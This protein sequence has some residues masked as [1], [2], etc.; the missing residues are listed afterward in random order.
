MN[1]EFLRSQLSENYLLVEAKPHTF[2]QLVDVI[3]SLD[4]DFSEDIED[5]VSSIT[6]DADILEDESQRLRQSFNSLL[7]GV[8]QASRKRYPFDEL[9]VENDPLE[10]FS[11]T[12]G[13]NFVRVVL[14][15]ITDLQAAHQYLLKTAKNMHAEHI[16]LFSRK[17]VAASFED[18]Q[19]F[20]VQFQM[21]SPTVSSFA[22]SILEAEDCLRIMVATGY[23]ISN[24]LEG[25]YKTLNHRHSSEGIEIHIDPITT[26]IAMAIYENVDSHGEIQDGKKPDELSIYTIRKAELLTES[27]KTGILGIFAKD[28]AQFIKF[29]ENELNKLW[30]SGK[31][32]STYAKIHADKIRKITRF[33]GRTSYIDK[34]RFEQAI[35]FIRDLNPSSMTYK[36]RT[37]LLT[38]E[39]RKDLEF[40]NA[41]ISTVARFISEGTPTTELIQYILSR[42]QELREYQLEENSFF[43]CKIG[44]GNAFTGDSPGEL[45]V[46]PG[47]KP[48]V[49]L[50]DIIGSGF[51]EV[52]DFMQHVLDGVKW[53]DIFLATSP[54]KKADKS[55]VL[56]VGPA[57]SG[58]TEC[59]RAVASAK[60][61]IGI[62]AQ[63]SDFLT[64]WKGEAERN[65]KRLF[66]AGLKIQKESKKQ[67]FFL[68]DEIDTILND[69]QGQNAFGGTNLATEFQVLMD[70]ITT[71][72]N[73]AL[74][75]AT[76]HPE[77]IP[78][79][80][81]RRFSKVIIV[82]ELNQADRIALLKQFLAFLPCSPEMTDEIIDGAAQALQGAVGDIVRKVVDNV[83]REKMSYFVSNYPE[84]AEKVLSILNSDGQKFHPSKLTQET[85]QAMFKVMSSCVQVTPEDLLRSIEK[86]IT[87]IAIRNEISTAVSVYDNARQFLAA[88]EK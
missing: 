71:Y 67:V 13:N 29:I 24:K 3:N 41:T 28:P 25:Y 62:F 44:S 45:K 6:A 50:S 46:I 17:L 38:V 9:M 65:P 19:A 48:S 18:L 73:L 59:L 82:G 1:T 60:K 37:G 49:D 70:G 32:L 68:I 52:V 80:L 20:T 76:N 2:Y 86:H 84:A 69:N 54:S 85:R 4:I 15:V 47:I 72:P 56:L 10:D 30:D 11:H 61:S 81:I 42:K 77:R 64:C 22:N 88:I 75:G 21:H 79:P 31:S 63:S 39:E 27:L 43:V 5:I 58:K 23:Q 8:R 16:E 26:D 35:I 74:W 57:G 51:K 34:D 36:E 78:M 83:W 87:N 33:K 55:N 53:F 14:G 7:E 66:E 40:K 12:N